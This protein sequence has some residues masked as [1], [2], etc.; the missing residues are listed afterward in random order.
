[1]P[2]RPT[3]ITA[4]AGEHFVAYKICVMNL[5]VALTRGGSPA[6]D[7]MV[8]DLKGSTAVSI[9]V[10][11][12]NW[13]RRTY[14]RT[15]ERNCWEWQ[16]GKK[17]LDLRGARIYYAFVDLKYKE[18]TAQMPDVFIVPSQGVADSL[19]PNWTRYLFWIKEDDK[20][21]YLEAWHLIKDALAQ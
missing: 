3:A 7:L 20:A 16:V 11:T 4:A 18:A 14:K 13:A 5:L 2:V 19:G 6:V 10:K 12:S 21:K 15:P 1:M 9:Q 8:G 17:A